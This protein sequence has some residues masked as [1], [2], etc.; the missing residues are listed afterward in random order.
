MGCRQGA[1]ARACWGREEDVFGGARWGTWRVSVQRGR[2]V[3]LPA[4]WF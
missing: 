4:A 3:W 1:D 2:F